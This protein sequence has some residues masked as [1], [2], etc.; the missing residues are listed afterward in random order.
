MSQPTSPAPDTAAS[1]PIDGPYDLGRTLGPLAFGRG[2]PTIR[3][4]GDR[5]WRAT[6][7]PDGPA[8]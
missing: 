6:R 2:D 4:E 5:A 8:T 1:L 7:T 3:I